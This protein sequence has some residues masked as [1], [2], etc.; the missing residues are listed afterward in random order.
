MNGFQLLNSYEPVCFHSA[1]DCS[2]STQKIKKWN[3][4]LYP[5]RKFDRGRSRGGSICEDY[6]G[7]ESSDKYFA[8]PPYSLCVRDNADTKCLFFLLGLHAKPLARPDSSK[9]HLQTTKQELDNFKTAYDYFSHLYGTNDAILM[10]DLNADGDYLTYAQFLYL[11][12]TK[13]G[14]GGWISYPIGKQHTNV[15]GD[16]MVHPAMYDR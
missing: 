6:R 2:N 16:S 9:P 11:E 14:Q 12:L 10:G 13:R 8:R 15:A 1:C 4:G 7:P 5:S 3:A